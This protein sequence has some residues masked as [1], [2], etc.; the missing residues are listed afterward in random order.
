MDLPKGFAKGADEAR[1][2]ICAELLRVGLRRGGI[3]LVHSSL[4]SLGHV[5]GG[6]ETVI[7][8]LLEALGPDGTLL[9]PALS[10]ELVGPEQPVFDVLR[11]PSNVG[12]IP[13]HFRTRSGTLRSIHPTH[14]VCGVGRLAGG[15]LAEHHLD[16]TPVGPHSPFR[17]VRDLGGQILFLGCGLR[18]N[19]SMH[20]VEELAEVP[21][22]FG[23]TYIY[24]IIDAQGR[25]WSAR[26][27][28]HNFAGWRQRYDRVADLLTAGAEIKAGRVLQAT[29]HILQA[30][31][32]WRRA[33]EALRSDPFY[34]V[35]RRR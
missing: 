10:Y 4:S 5:P 35:E 14:S 22:L 8:G 31:P 21:Y 3:V 11:T 30:R 28:H 1:R 12:A 9:M 7:L 34:F 16:D 25:E 6:P 17:R 26:H 32:M 15:I 24:R 20:G 29:V 19:T 23:E 2:R 18:P 13:E 27:R 33:L